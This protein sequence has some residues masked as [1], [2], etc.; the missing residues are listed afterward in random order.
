MD[1][2]SPEGV[3]GSK[4]CRDESL[5]TANVIVTFL[6]DFPADLSQNFLP[7]ADSNVSPPQNHLVATL[8]HLL[9][10]DYPAK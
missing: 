2:I 1:T 8:P 3:N 5:L 9:E 10:S 4:Q 6:A 7:V